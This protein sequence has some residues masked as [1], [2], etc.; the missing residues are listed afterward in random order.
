MSSRDDRPYRQMIR[1][2]MS[3]RTFLKFSAAM[4]AALALPASYAPRIAAAVET[5]PRVPVIWLRGQACGGDSRAFLQAAEPTIAELVPRPPLGRLRRDAHG[6]SR[7]RRRASPGPPR[8]R[9]PNGYLAVVEGAI[10]TGD[11]GVVLHGRRAGRS[12]TSSRE[13]CAGAI[14][15]IAV[16]SC[17]FDGGAPGGGGRH[18]RRRRGRGAS[19]PDGHAHQPA[20][21]PAQRR[22][23]DRDDRPLPDLQG[24]LPPTDAPGPAALRL[25]RPDPQPVRAARPLRV[26]RVRPGLGRRGGPE[27][28]VPLQDGLQGPGDVRQLPDGPLRR[29]DELAGPGRARLHRLHDAPGSGTRWVRPTTRLPAPLPFAPT[30]HGRPGGAWS[31]SA[32]SP[33]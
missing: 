28:L 12:A 21:L 11:G 15:T 2:G 6:A 25:R 32:G 18:D 4:A 29:R 5:A 3:R 19:S 8:W 13:V 16:G 22:Q 17:A 14:A 9:G 31:S 23:P 33:P 26:R 24:A 1:R 10:P 7:E 30:G 27:G 20:R